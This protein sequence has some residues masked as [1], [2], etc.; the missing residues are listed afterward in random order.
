MNKK[1]KSTKCNNKITDI[2]GIAGTQIAYLNLGNVIANLKASGYKGPFVLGDLIISSLNRELAICA[3]ISA[4]ISKSEITLKTIVEY[5]DL[6]DA[7]KERILSLQDYMFDWKIID[8]E[9]NRVAKG[10]YACCIEMDDERGMIAFR[11]SE[12]ENSLETKR[13]WFE[14]DF[15]LLNSRGTWQQEEVDKYL[16]KIV[17]KGLLDKHGTVFAVGHSLGGN[18]A[19]HALVCMANDEKK[20]TLFNKVKMA[21]NYDGPGFSEEYLE[22]YS[23]AVVKAAP[24]IKH[25]KWSAIGDLLFDI[26]GIKTVYWSINEELHKND[27]LDRIKYKV[28]TRHSTKSLVYDKNGMAKEGK[29]DIVSKGLSFI[30]KAVDVIIP[31][32]LTIE[33]FA[34]ADWIFDK[35][36]SV[37]YGNHINFGKLSW[38]ERSAEN[39]SILGM[40]TLCIK[41]MLRVFKEGALSLKNELSL[42]NMAPTL[43]FAGAGT[44]VSG[45]IILPNNSRMLD[46]RND[47]REQ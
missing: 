30:S 7:D 19:E 3:A 11:G 34:V 24:K 6:D 35:I 41:N 5:S 23:E 16:N 26:P 44:N 45:T 33:A 21:Y 12:S 36:L 39:G 28:I 42:N 40:C 37:E 17:S 27:I 8:V 38:P 4:G 29:Q 20:R 9:D 25:V 10:F 31:E 18:L 15:G 13:T 43:A 46:D 14:A 22:T 32:W 1:L 2:E 47:E